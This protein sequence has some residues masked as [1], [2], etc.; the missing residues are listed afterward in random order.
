MPGMQ[1]G[2]GPGVGGHHET[3]VVDI[4]MVV[5]TVTVVVSHQALVLVTDLGYLGLGVGVGG[6]IRKPMVGLEIRR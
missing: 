4:N 3:A 2:R 5:A 1:P 6:W